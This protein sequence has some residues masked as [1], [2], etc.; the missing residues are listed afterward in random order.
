LGLA[1]PR[2]GVGD[3]V[4]VPKADQHR[5]E[6]NVRAPRNAVEPEVVSACVLLGQRERRVDDATAQWV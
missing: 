6:R 2:P 4:G 3:G 5:R 1:R